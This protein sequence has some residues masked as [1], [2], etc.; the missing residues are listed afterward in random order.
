MVGSLKLPSTMAVRTWAKA[1]VSGWGLAVVTV[2]L[3]LLKSLVLLGYISEKPYVV[4][5]VIGA[6]QNLPIFLR[7][8]LSWIGI[9]VSPALLFKSTGRSCYLI[10]LNLA[11]SLLSLMD[12]W[13]FRALN[14]FTSVYHLREAGNLHN[15]S[16]AILPYIHATDFL[17]LADVIGLCVYLLW[18]KGRRA[19]RRIPAFAAILALSVVTLAHMSTIEIDS[20]SMFYTRWRPVE[21]IAT[22]S[23]IGY[24]LHDLYTFCTEPAQL[25]LSSEDRK[26][27]RDWFGRK[28][29]YLPPNKYFGRFRGYN[30]LLLQCESL[31][32]F[33]INKTI[34]GQVITP[35]LNGLLAQSLYFN[36]YMEQVAD[37]TSMDSEYMVNTSVYPLETGTASWRFPNNTYRSLPRL[38]AERGYWTADYH[39]DPASYWNWGEL[40]RNLG[41][42]QCLDARNFKQD[43]IIDLGL[44]DGSFL[45]QVAPDL[46]KLRQPFYAYLITLT[47]HGPFDLPKPLR[48]LKL[49]EKLD[50]TEIGGYLQSVH[51]MDKHIG[52]L[53]ARLD[54][55]GL[56]EHTLVGIFGDHCGIHKFSEESLA[57]MSE[58]TRQW[59]E[60]GKRIPLI[61]YQKH[62]AG[63]CISELGGQIDALPTLSYLMGV[64]E[65][66]V[67][68]FA[69]G[70]NLLN[71]H[72]HFVVLQDGTFLSSVDS[73]REREDALAGIEL[74][75]KIVFSNY[76]NSS[77][78]Q[79]PPNAGV[80]TAQSKQKPASDEI[81]SRN[82]HNQ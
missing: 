25:E 19:P 11:I 23:P 58:N 75:Q 56:L 4:P 71:T 34:G 12:L 44:S 20:C 81:K 80:H 59:M 62:Q 64:D 67:E 45:N 9:V 68:G 18:R 37:G 65:K 14:R 38:L 76:F 22:I 2:L 43:E 27:I 77:E 47:N 32:N 66:K 78:N 46:I 41:M 55:A 79:L 21:T 7:I 60:N 24:H 6:I 54:A 1:A 52:I 10:I 26:Q 72:K 74:A 63:E 35:T 82:E 48:E 29:E 51:Y 36:N 31:E 8:Y 17:L 40:M 53:L 61:L 15:L 13:Y 28:N 69:M 50:Q 39:P 3:L 16:S 57:K 73:K 70:R 30:L 49:D 33:V 5:A 42:Q